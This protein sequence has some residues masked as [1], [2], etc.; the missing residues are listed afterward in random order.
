VENRNYKAHFLKMFVYLYTTNAV[1][2]HP[3]PRTG[4]TAL[5]LRGYNV[6]ECGARPAV[7]RE[8]FDL[9]RVG[10]RLLAQK[11]VGSPG[12]PV[13]VARDEDSPRLLGV[14]LLYEGLFAFHLNDG[15]SD[16]HEAMNQVGLLRKRWIR[17]DTRRGFRHER[18][19]FGGI[20]GAVNK[21]LQCEAAR[22]QPNGEN[23]H[24]S[25]R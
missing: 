25:E 11:S 4:R 12:P 6:A 8:E 2:P 20:V 9:P 22:L 3:Q 19:V 15:I 14:D 13:V 21:R 10:I 7:A 5:G 1:M 18:S 23:K 17:F 24:S 16:E